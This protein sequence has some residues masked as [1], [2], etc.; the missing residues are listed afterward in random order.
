MTVLPT[1]SRQPT[2]LPQSVNLAAQRHDICKLNGVIDEQSIR[3]EFERVL[4]NWPDWEV[5]Y[6]YADAFLG[7][8]VDARLNTPRSGV[9][10]YL[11]FKRARRLSPHVLQ[12]WWQLQRDAEQSLSELRLFAPIVWGEAA[13]N[14]PAFQFLFPWAAVGSTMTEAIVQFGE[15]MP[16]IARLPKSGKVEVPSP[17]DLVNLDLARF[18]RSHPSSLDLLI[19]DANNSKDDLNYESGFG[20]EQHFIFATVQDGLEDLGFEADELKK[21]LEQYRIFQKDH[22]DILTEINLQDLGGDILINVNRLIP[23]SYEEARGLMSYITSDTK[24]PIMLH[25]FLK[26]VSA[27]EIRFLQRRAPDSKFKFITFSTLGERL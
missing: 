15:R 24:N 22:P 6:E 18:I 16:H 8:R 14:D 19:S 12:S 1:A 17:F 13:P 11:E 21:Y 20:E 9:K 2:R 23:D 26:P 27:Q 3:T 5:R 10:V 4:S 7:W 25:G